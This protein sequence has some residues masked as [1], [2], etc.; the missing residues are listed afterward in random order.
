MGREGGKRRGEEESEKREGGG[1]GQDEGKF[2]MEGETW[3]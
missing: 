2:R 3:E 1:K